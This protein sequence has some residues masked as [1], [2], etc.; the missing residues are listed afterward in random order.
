MLTVKGGT[1]MQKGE[2]TAIETTKADTGKPFSVTATVKNSG[3]YHYY[4]VVSN[5]TVNDVQGKTVATVKTNPMSRA[6]CTWPAGKDHRTGCT[7]SS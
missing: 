3:N 1:I 6:I 4:G 7:R 5:V 2:I